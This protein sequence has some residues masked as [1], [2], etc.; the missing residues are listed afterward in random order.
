MRGLNRRGMWR[1]FQLLQLR[2]QP[3]LL[4]LVLS[5]ALHALLLQPV[6]APS[7]RLI[8]SASAASPPVNIAF[9]TAPRPLLP[10]PIAAQAEAEVDKFEPN[11]AEAPLKQALAR[12]EA[13]PK[14]ASEP[15]Q[16]L[17][18]E[19]PSAE[20][21]QIADE[22]PKAVTEAETV[23]E[24]K[25]EQA[26]M[27]QDT[28]AVS[29]DRLL[30]VITEP[31]FSAQPQLPVYPKLA[32]KRR[33]QGQALVQALVNEQGATERVELVQSTGYALLDQ[34]AL[35]AVSGW[36]FAAA[37]ENSGQIR[38]WVQVPVNFTIR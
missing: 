7:L 1:Q 13:L 36:S 20:R 33:W 29:D 3:L 17:S 8:S 38:A 35:K 24:A 4:T 31:S 11:M 9:A 19:Q 27:V 34:S 12:D 25:A 2:R 15:V 26:Q 37:E 10:P 22:Q 6:K 5:V 14:V 16:G 21:K 30:P 18:Q 28:P 32:L 23:A